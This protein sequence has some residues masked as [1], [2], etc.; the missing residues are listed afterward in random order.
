M[1]EIYDN[2]FK[3][4]THRE[5]KNRL[6]QKSWT[7]NGGSENSPMWHCDFL[8]KDFYFNTYLYREIC[9]NLGREFRSIERIYANGQTAAQCGTPHKDDGDLTFLYYPAFEWP[10]DNQGHLIFLE[11]NEEN[12]EGQT[13]VLHKP[14]RA[15]LF[16]ANMWHYADAPCRFFKGLRISLAYKLLEYETL[17][18]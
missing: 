4:D 13:I 10:V 7:F 11:E 8:S 3:E 5:V 9:K 6:D 15:V 12:I 1:I 16:T 18:N 17:S 2:F 14:N